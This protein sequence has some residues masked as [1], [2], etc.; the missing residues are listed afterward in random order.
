MTDTAQKVT[1]TA[2]GEFFGGEVFFF[3]SMTNP[4]MKMF[5]DVF[6]VAWPKFDSTFSDF[7]PDMDTVVAVECIDDEGTLKRTPAPNASL[8]Q[9]RAIIDQ[10]ETLLIDDAELRFKMQPKREVIMQKI[11]EI[12]LSNLG[13]GVPRKPLLGNIGTHE[14]HCCSTHGC[15]YGDDDCPVRMKLVFQDYPCEVCEDENYT[16]NDYDNDEY[17]QY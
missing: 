11:T 4:H 15:K 17:Y 16:D 13:E 12:L 9:E 5:K 7:V 6:A 1:Y 2:K 3:I 14:S 10:D 8:F